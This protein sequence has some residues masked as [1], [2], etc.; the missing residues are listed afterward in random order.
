MGCCQSAQS[1][2][3]EA[4]AARSRNRSQCH[5]ILFPL[6]RL[7]APLFFKQHCDTRAGAFVELTTLVAA[8]DAFM[9]NRHAAYID[10]KQNAEFT[11]VRN[12]L[13]EY[14]VFFTGENG[15]VRNPDISYVQGVVSGL[16]LRSF[17]SSSRVT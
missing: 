5:D 2:F 15:L 13:F 7:D 14:C 12:F 16:A 1:A 9:V 17:P 4:V 8:F 10:A 11:F 6:V 3:D